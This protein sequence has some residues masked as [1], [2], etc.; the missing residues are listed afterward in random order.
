[1]ERRTHGNKGRSGAV[2]RQNSGGRPGH[3][4]PPR[5]PAIPAAGLH[6]NRSFLTRADRDEIIQWLGTIQPIWEKKFS[7]HNPPPP[8]DTQRTLLRPIYWLGNWQFACLRYYMPPKGTLNRCIEAEP[9]PPVLRRLVDKIERTVRQ[10][11][12]GDDLPKG[13]HFNTCLVNLYGNKVENGKEIDCARVG[14]HKDLE[15]GPVA[16]ISLGERALFQ[17]VSSQKHN[18][19]SEVVVE[20]WLDDGSLQI[21]GGERWK[22]ELFHRVQRVDGKGGYTF[23]VSVEGFETRRLNFTFRYVP[24]EHIVPFVKLPREAREDVREYMEKLAETSPFFAAE[25]KRGG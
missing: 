8:G 17:F 9:F 16:S 25:L 21:F 18:D 2:T 14:E 15:P 24:T 20:Q 7:T 3:R 22:N 13:W 5:R 11:F 19:K 10:M 23:P 1:M 4:S 12:R 6:Y